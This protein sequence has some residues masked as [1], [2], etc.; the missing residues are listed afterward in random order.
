[1]P[2][3]RRRLDLIIDDDVQ[4]AIGR[5]NADGTD[6]L[7]AK[8]AEATCFDHR[9]ATRRFARRSELSEAE[10]LAAI[11]DGAVEDEFELGQLTADEFLRTSVAG[12]LDPRYVLAKRAVDV[13]LTTLL[14]VLAVPVGLLIALAIKLEDPSAPV[15]FTQRRAGRGGRTFPLLKFRTM[16]PGAHAMQDALRDRS[17]LAWPVFRMPDDPRLN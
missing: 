3:R 14:L 8:G 2:R 11:Y 7:G 5:L 16:V 1:M 9:R 17:V 13:V 10:I 6:V 15:L 4:H 12:H